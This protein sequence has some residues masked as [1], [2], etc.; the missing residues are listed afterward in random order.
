MPEKRFNFVS[1]Q[2]LHVN[3]GVAVSA[4]LL[5]LASYDLDKLVWEFNACR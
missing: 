1:V 2:D 5:V 4:V 3:Y